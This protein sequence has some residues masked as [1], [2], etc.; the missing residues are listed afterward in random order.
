MAQELAQL[1]VVVARAVLPQTGLRVVLSPSVA[2]GAAGRRPCQGRAVDRRAQLAIGRIVDQGNRRAGGVGGGDHAALMVRVV[3]VDGSI[4]LERSQTTV[5]R[6]RAVRDEAAQDI[7][8][9]VHLGHL[10]R[11]RP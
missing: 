11:A 6:A 9:L 7:A 5:H 1:G 3:P 8:R 2:E 4:G 10:V